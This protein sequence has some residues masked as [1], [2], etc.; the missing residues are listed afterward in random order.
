MALIYYARRAPIGNFV[1]LN[2]G[3]LLSLLC[4]G[5]SKQHYEWLH[6]R[7]KA[8]T[9]ATMFIE[10]KNKDE[11][12]KYKIGR[13]ESLHIVDKFLYDDKT[14]Q[15][16]FRLDPRWVQMFGNREYGLAD[17]TKR[18]QISRGQ[19]MAKTLQRLVTTSSDP[20]QRY[21]LE[22]LKKKM[23][24]ESPMRKF[25]ESLAAAIRELER[26]EIIG[27]GRIQLSTRDEEQLVLWLSLI[28]I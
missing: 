9:E 24:Y 18:M 5:R 11:T 16:A 14:Q 25:K 8:M 10:A 3:E 6:R 23:Q 22:W 28:H 2:R 7:M 15:Y 21:E 17:W 27:R 19:D 20:T 1:V 13:T 12:T 4:R 26:V